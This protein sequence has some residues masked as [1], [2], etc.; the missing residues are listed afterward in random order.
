MEDAQK[1][2]DFVTTNPLEQF[3]Q[4]TRD[5][6]PTY[7]LEG[8]SA[9]GIIGFTN[10]HAFDLGNYIVLIRWFQAVGNITSNYYIRKKII[11]HNVCRKVVIEPSV[12]EK[13][14]INS[15]RVQVKGI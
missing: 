13:L 10:Q 12:K 5:V 14:T 1:M 7:P 8:S 9:D 2:Y 6:V 4:F 15:Y 3:G 11:V